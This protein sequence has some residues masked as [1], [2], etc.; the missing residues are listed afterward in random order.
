M[1][2]RRL[3]GELPS[4]TK[5]DKKLQSQPVEVPKESGTIVGDV[6]S[7]QKEIK[8]L[9]ETVKKL[10]SELD[11]LK[12]KKS[13]IENEMAMPEVFSNADK[14]QSLNLSLNELNQNIQ[15]LQLRWETAFAELIEAES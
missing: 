10:E 5:Q 9:S 12:S 11:Q 3:N 15:E 14:I 13:G 2:R 1:E 8:K 6:K 4:A 7:K